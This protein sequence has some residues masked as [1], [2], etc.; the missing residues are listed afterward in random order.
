M[1]EFMREASELAAENLTANSGGPFGAVVVKDGKIIGRGR[2]HVLENNDPT[3]HGEIMAIR[4]ACSNTGSYDL[5][6]CTLYTS[7]YPCPM[8][9]AA[10][11]WAN[12]KK[13]YYGNTR[14]DAAR[15]GFRDDFLYDMMGKLSADV[16]GA[17]NV[18]L[19]QLDHEETIKVFNAFA[20]KE[21][22]TIY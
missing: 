22:R 6:G 4:D 8:C 17:E 10:T 13:I 7:A 11:V 1:N 2:N 12:I 19:K 9:M 3:A 5:S 15:I 18:E 16:E 21:D 20:E 14:E